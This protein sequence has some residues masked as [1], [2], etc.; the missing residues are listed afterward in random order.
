MKIWDDKLTRTAKHSNQLAGTTTVVT[1]GYHIVEHA[2]V[3][4]SQVREYIDK[5][6][7]SLIQV[8]SILIRN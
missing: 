6:I 2:V 3:G 8:V 7:C 1:D 4:L 5:D